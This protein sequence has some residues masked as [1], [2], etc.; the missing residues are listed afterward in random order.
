[1]SRQTKPTGVKASVGQ[2]RA[3]QGWARRGAMLDEGQV[4]LFTP[5][6]IVKHLGTDTLLLGPPTDWPVQFVVYLH[7]GWRWGSRVILPA[8]TCFEVRAAIPTL[9][10]R[11]CIALEQVGEG[12]GTQG[13]FR[14]GLG[15]EFRAIAHGLPSPSA[16]E[17]K[18]WAPPFACWLPAS[19]PGDPPISGPIYDFE[20]AVRYAS[21]WS[22]VEEARTYDILSAHQRYL[23]LTG[24]AEVEEDEALLKE[25]EEVGHLLPDPPGCVDERV[26]LYIAAVTG[27]GIGDIQAVDRGEMAYLDHL[28]LVTWDYEGE[29][30]E[31]LGAPHWVL[32]NLHPLAI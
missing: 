21:A 6:R 23:E 1:M 9:G 12:W 24:I 14:E 22:G 11:T 27:H 30:D 26:E 10:G 29:R 20:E 5:G 28:G 8:D 31:R 4:A 2:E 16:K 25:R 17:R 3:F 32:G 19:R 7:L 18:Q 13:Q 15:R